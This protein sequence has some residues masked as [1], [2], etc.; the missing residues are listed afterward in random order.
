MEGLK[1]Q[2]V[3]DNWIQMELR[4]DQIHL[5]NQ[6]VQGPILRRHSDKMLFYKW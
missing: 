2:K 3:Q 1:H 4:H 5:D 6:M